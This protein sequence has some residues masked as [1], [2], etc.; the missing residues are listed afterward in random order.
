MLTSLFFDLVLDN[1]GKYFAVFSSIVRLNSYLDLLEGVEV[2]A[3]VAANDEDF[4]F[5][6][7]G[8]VEHVSILDCIIGA[9]VNL[10]FL[11][12]DALG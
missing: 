10:N 7:V 8:G 1:G 2:R 12:N 6:G 11:L 9:T 3:Q 4:S 5:K